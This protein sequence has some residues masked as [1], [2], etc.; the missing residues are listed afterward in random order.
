LQ[1]YRPAFGY[2]ALY[3]AAP[4]DRAAA[5][6]DEQGL[7]MQSS[8]TIERLNR[9]DRG[10]MERRVRQVFA[11]RESGDIPAMMRLVAPDLVCFPA[12]SWR[13]AVPRAIV[14]KE[15]VAEAFRL[16]NIQ[17]ENLGSTIHSL[18]IDGDRVVV[19][20]TSTIRDRG[21]SRSITYD[22]INFFRFRDGLIVEFTEL[23]DGSIKGATNS[24]PL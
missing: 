1:Y 6:K 21:G 15:A 10:L 14:G 7:E 22:A 20:R 3:R 24:F 2:S 16:R 9:L 23:P 8:E 11:L 12:T 18:L 5:G 13:Y 4:P 19:H 17:Y